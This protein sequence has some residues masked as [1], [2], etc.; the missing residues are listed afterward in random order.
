LDEFDLFDDGDAASTAAVLTQQSLIDTQ[1][2]LGV[3]LDIMPIGLLIHTEQGILFANQA[4]CGLLGSERQ[5]LIGQ[6]LLDFVRSAEIGQAA[7][8]FQSSFQVGDKIFRG[9]AVVGADERRQRLVRLITGRLPWQ[10]NPVIQVLLE[11]ITDQRRAENSLRQMTITDE[12]TGAYNRRHAFYEAS[13][14]IDANQ[15]R[16]VPFSVALIDIDRF[17]SIN[18][19]LGHGVGDLALKRLAALANAFC[20]LIPGTDSAMFARIGGEEFVVLMPGLDIRAASAV[21]EDFRSS[22]EQM[23]MPLPEGVL[24]F[25]VSIGVAELNHADQDFTGLLRRADEALYE[26]KGAGRNRVI[27]APTKH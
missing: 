27:A 8:Q 12:L 26:A 11:D 20:P 4:A 9:E 24:R 7:E 14:H 10:G 15:A 3:M 18:D 22:V 6:H 19:K 25:T 2:R 5:A 21:A 1:H 17:K 23:S 16:G 13:L